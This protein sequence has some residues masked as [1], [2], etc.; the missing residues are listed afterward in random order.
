M[1]EYPNSYKTQCL[2]VKII[3]LVPAA[4]CLG[5]DLLPTQLPSTIRMHL[6]EWSEQPRRL[7][8]EYEIQ[9]LTSKKT[10]RNHI[11]I[12]SVCISTFYVHASNALAEKYGCW[13]WK[14]PIPTIRGV[15]FRIEST[16][17]WR[18][19]AWIDFKHVFDGWIMWKDGCWKSQDKGITN[20]WSD[21][22]HHEE[23]SSTSDTQYQ[24][25]LAS[26][27]QQ[28]ETGC[29][30]LLSLLAL[31]MVEFGGTRKCGLERRLFWK[32]ALWLRKI[33]QKYSINN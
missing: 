20:S 25:T 28:C 31:A 4:R 33:F 2:A 12:M 22:L 21:R 5:T 23:A 17:I 26:R 27:Q 8:C 32:Y 10:P 14:Y 11:Q 1:R 18:S 9:I 29:S 30:L 15:P 13:V 19:T 3:R 7:R 24:Y 16:A 6:S